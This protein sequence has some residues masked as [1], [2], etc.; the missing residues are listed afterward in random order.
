[1]RKTCFVLGCGQTGQ[2]M[3]E[4]N[5]VYVI[6]VN[7]SFKFNM[8]MDS[9]LFINRP[10][11]FHEP[12][13]DVPNTSRIEIIKHTYCN[14]ILTLET[15][16]REWSE[17]FPQAIIRTFTVTRWRKEAQRNQVYHTDSSPFTAMSYA[18]TQGFDEIVLWGVDF[19][20]HKYLRP[21]VSAPC[22]NQFASA[23]AKQGCNIY[24]GHK[25]SKLN[26]PLYEVR[27]NNS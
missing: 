21:E 8:S 3:P 9:L 26:L 1:M 14:Q 23:V 6:G 24:K 11:H 27:S 5:D 15:L 25:E 20:N 16:A 2:Y 18:F 13:L 7:D 17:V 4:V 22:F 19:I 12:S 10:R